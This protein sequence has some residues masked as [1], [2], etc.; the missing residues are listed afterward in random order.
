MKEKYSYGEV[1]DGQDG[2]RRPAFYQTF[3]Q[4]TEPFGLF[5]IF[6]SM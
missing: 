1:D 2:N 5:F 4:L 6:E 3:R